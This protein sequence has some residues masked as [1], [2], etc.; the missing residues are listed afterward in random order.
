[1]P[2]SEQLE[3]KSKCPTYP[4][5]TL[6][7]EVK[8]IQSSLKLNSLKKCQNFL[9]KVKKEQASVNFKV[10]VAARDI[11][12]LYKNLLQNDSLRAED[13]SLNAHKDAPLHP[14]SAKIKNQLQ[15]RYA[16]DEDNLLLRPRAQV[17]SPN[18]DNSFEKSNQAAMSPTVD[19]HM[20]PARPQPESS[21]QREPEA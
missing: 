12:A 7:E 9:Q 11:S 4:D 20:S 19:T 3:N 13:F 10:G 15:V 21:W 16:A 8:K 1:M 5:A 2:C 18:L 6:N 17:H 14:L